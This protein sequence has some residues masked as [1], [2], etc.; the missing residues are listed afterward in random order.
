[1][2]TG[3][4]KITCTTTG[5][6]YFGKT[7][8]P[9]CE[10]WAAH[11]Y[12]LKHPTKPHPNQ[13][14]QR[15]WDKYGEENFIFEVVERCTV[16]EL[17]NREQYYMDNVVNWG[18]DF[19]ICRESTSGQLGRKHTEETKKKLSLALKGKPGPNKGKTFSIEYR[20][21]LSDAHKG[22]RLGAGRKNDICGH[23]DLE[24]GAKGMC[25]PCYDKQRRPPRKRKPPSIEAREKMS[26]AHKGQVSPNKGKKASEETRSKQRASRLAFL[27]KQKCQ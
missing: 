6:I 22:Q 12:D 15:A 24:H 8:K 26:I 1:M 10:R 4:Y 25:Q 13:H 2:L 9:F 3:I 11:R 16:E 14:L 7:S 17:S 18:W 23:L 19:N 27:E 21:R 5:K 20:K